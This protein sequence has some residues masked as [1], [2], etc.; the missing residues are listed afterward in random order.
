[1]EEKNNQEKKNKELLQ[2]EVA[3]LQEAPEVARE[4]K[5]Q[6]PDEVINKK[7]RQELEAMD[8][9]D[10]VKLQARAQSLQAKNLPAKEQITYLLG[11]AKSK[12]VVYAVKVAKDMQDPYLLDTFHDALAK[13]GYYK[14]FLK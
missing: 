8:A 13:N 14:E 1:M 12:G 5:D 4:R 10:S 7:I 2:E 9:D 6:T 11:L 3:Q